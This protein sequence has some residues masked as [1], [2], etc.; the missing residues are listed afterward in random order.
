MKQVAKGGERFYAFGAVVRFDRALTA[1]EQ[2]RTGLIAT[3]W[4]FR[5]HLAPGRALP[6]PLFGGTG[7]GRVGA[8]GKHCYL[9]EVATVRAWHAVRLGGAWRVALHD[10]RTVL[11]TAPRVVA[12]KVGVPEQLRQAGCV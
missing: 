1:A 7:L 2:R 5:A 6:D 3:Q 11:R 9:A 12:A 4:I 8:R 10:G